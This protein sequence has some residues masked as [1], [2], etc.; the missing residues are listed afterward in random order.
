MFPIRIFLFLR[1]QSLW[2]VVANKS[3]YIV[4]LRVAIMQLH[5]CGVTWNASVTLL[6]L[7][8]VA[9]AASAVKVGVA[10]QINRTRK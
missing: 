1:W 10:Y 2:I 9:D 5:N 7:P 3:N 6:E 4:R 8:P